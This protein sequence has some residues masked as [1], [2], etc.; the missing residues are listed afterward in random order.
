MHL[1]VC[2]SY[3]EG[4]GDESKWYLLVKTDILINKDIIYPY[5]RLLLWENTQ[6]YSIR[7]IIFKGTFSVSV[8]YKS[9]STIV[10]KKLKWLPFSYL[11]KFGKIFHCFTFLY[12][13]KHF[14]G[15]LSITKNNAKVFITYMPCLK[16][17]NV[18]LGLQLDNI[19]DGNPSLSR[20]F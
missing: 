9:Q 17:S 8:N 14:F 2:L 3:M 20:N 5:L 16:N 7:S 10:N 13:L 19:G 15:N 18:E 11:S 12:I 4:T 1:P 6:M